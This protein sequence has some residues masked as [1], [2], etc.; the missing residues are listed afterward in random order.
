MEVLLA[1]ANFSIIQRSLM[2][3]HFVDPQYVTAANE[4]GLTL[5]EI[6]KGY[7]GACVSAERYDALVIFL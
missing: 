6:R 4:A 7:V 3:L 1:R 5:E 2:S